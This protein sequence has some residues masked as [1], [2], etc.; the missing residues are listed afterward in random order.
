MKT[1]HFAEGDGAAFLAAVQ[2]KK[3]RKAAKDARPGLPRAK[4]GEG[5]RIAAL[6]RIAKLGYGPRWDDTGFFFWNPATDGRT[7]VHE[8]YAEACVAAEKELGR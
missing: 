7:S 1:E 6:M 4:Q 8:S 5:D 2:G 3:P